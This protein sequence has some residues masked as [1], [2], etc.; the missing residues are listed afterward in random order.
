[1]TESLKAR[2]YVYC[3]LFLSSFVLYFNTLSHDYALDDAIVI[4]DNDFTQKGFSGIVDH[5]TNESFTGFFKEEK[6]LVSG[7]RYRPL[8]FITFSIEYQ[9]FGK[10]PGIS[11]FFNILIYAILSIV[12]FNVLNLLLKPYNNPWYFS[13]A[14]LTTLFFVFHPIHTEVVANIKGRDEMLTLLGALLALYY[15]IKYVQT[16]IPVKATIVSKSDKKSK[17]QQPEKNISKSSSKNKYLVFAAIS[18]FLG[19]MSKENAITFLAIIP[20]ALYFFTDTP[21]KKI[22]V[23]IMPLLAV[24]FL[25]LF[26]RYNVVGFTSTEEVKE[27]LNNP[28]LGMSTGEKAGTIIH[29]LGK[30]IE[31]LIFPNVLTYDYYPYHIPVTSLLSPRPVFYLVIYAALIYFAV[32]SL[33]TKSVIG[34]GLIIYL[35]SLSVVS[36]IVFPVGTFMNERFVFIPSIGF[37]LILAWGIH[38]VLNSHN[39]NIYRYAVI[40]FSGV[41]LLIFSIKTIDRNK[42]WKD[43]LTLFTTDVK[44]SPMSAKSTCSAGGKLLEYAK[45]IKDSAERFSYLELSKKYLIQSTDNYNILIPNGIYVDAEM[46]LGNCYFEF[47][48][49]DSTLFH[50][51]RICLKAPGNEKVYQNAAIT[52]NRFDDI[53]KKIAETK[54]FYRH[55]PN[56]F[57]LNYNLGKWYGQYKN[58][59]DSAIFYLERAVYFKKNSKEAL[60][61]LGVA[62]GFKQRY[63]DAITVLQR[64]LVVAPKDEQIYF[65]LAITYS[66]LQDYKNAVVNFEKL[67]QMNPQNGNYKKML[68]QAKALE[69]SNNS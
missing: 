5:L 47:G 55:N 68:E 50:Y 29:T 38:Y 4:T 54:A 61:D 2:W 62:Y 34:F 52:I 56:V 21:K 28:F 57:E 8:S 65:N 51:K 10:S 30:Y 43:D 48:K 7:G 60:K 69:K 6:K 39:K 24:S 14:F 19:L 23:A 44:T 53:D 32:R 17:T 26:I 31:L 1:M 46:L 66:Y 67:V 13:V 20:I 36:N 35:S 41:V 9:F 22:F 59:L 3:I 27:L 58:N 12:L 42:A 49:F 63:S 64:A 11:H 16:E 25:F 37:L 45:E 40:I 33:R 15:L 18:F